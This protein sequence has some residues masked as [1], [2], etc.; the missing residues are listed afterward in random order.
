KLMNKHLP[1]FRNSEVLADIMRRRNCIHSS[2][3]LSVCLNSVSSVLSPEARPIILLAP[4]RPARPRPQCRPLDR[5]LRIFTLFSRSGALQV[6]D[7]HALFTLFTIKS[8]P[9]GRRPLAVNIPRENVIT[10]KHFYQSD[11]G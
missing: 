8:P 11:N 5:L 9:G 7:F 4:I 10:Q 3:E 1:L 6:L 2:S